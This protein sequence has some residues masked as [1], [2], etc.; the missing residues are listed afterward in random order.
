MTQEIPKATVASINSNEE[1]THYTLSTRIDSAFNLLSLAARLGAGPWMGYV[2]YE[3]GGADALYVPAMMTVMNTVSFLSDTLPTNQ[4]PIADRLKNNIGPALAMATC[5][6]IFGQQTLLSEKSPLI[7]GAVGAFMLPA[8]T[9][10][11][12]GNELHQ[13]LGLLYLLASKMLVM[14]AMVG[15]YKATELTAVLLLLG[16]EAIQTGR[17]LAPA[18]KRQFDLFRSAPSN[19]LHAGEASLLLSE[20]GRAALQAAV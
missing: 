8:F 20:E 9:H 7:L 5:A 19:T 15:F 10:L 3:K 18:A 16:D 2:N 12:A 13:K 14:A 6:F 4:K 1:S 17:V 11:A